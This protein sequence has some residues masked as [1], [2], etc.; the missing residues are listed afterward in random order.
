LL[1]LVIQSVET[2]RKLLYIEASHRFGEHWKTTLEYH[3]FFNQNQP[4]R[5]AIYD[6]RQDDYV[7]V[8]LFYYF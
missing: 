2:D 5:D 7:R 1:G 3:G 8:A 6:I 4:S